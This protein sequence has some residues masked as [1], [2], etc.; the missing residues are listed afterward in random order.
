MGNEVEMKIPISR[1]NLDKIISI[2]NGPGYTVDNFYKK[3][4]KLYT[5]EPE[6]QELSKKGTVVRIRSSGKLPKSG[7]KNILLENRQ[8]RS[9]AN[10]CYFTTKIKSTSNG[11][12]NNIE[13]ELLIDNAETMDA[14]LKDMGYRC[15]F[16][17]VKY[18]YGV[19]TKRRNQTYHVEL[20]R[21][22][23]TITKKDVLYVEIENTESSNN[24]NTTLED[25]ISIFEELGLSVNDADDRPWVEILD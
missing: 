7:L 12:E 21:A 17:K 20:E 25:I 3:E 14:C 19:Y 23:S 10:E 22:S 18:S 8:F 13:H 6:G 11:I 15:W 1:F 9:I 5:K 2:L 4:D 16:E 24:L